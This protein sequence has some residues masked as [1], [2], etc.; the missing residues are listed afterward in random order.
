MRYGVESIYQAMTYVAYIRI[1]L[2]RRKESVCGFCAFF[3][4]FIHRNL[5]YLSCVFLP[6]CIS[7][8][9]T[10]PACHLSTC[11]QV[12]LQWWAPCWLTSMPTTHTP[13]RQ[14][15]TS[16]LLIALLPRTLGW[17]WN[18]YSYKSNNCRV[19]WWE[20]VSVQDNVL[21]H[22]TTTTNYLFAHLFLFICC[23][24]LSREYIH[25]GNIRLPHGSNTLMLSTQW[26]L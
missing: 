20:V 5:I 1:V 6:I 10:S 22:W 13:P 12:F 24:K 7:F 21:F 14:Q 18:T 25:Y 23:H 16:L 15:T 4:V 19:K 8:A 17:V 3:I 9:V 2:F 11:A 26:H